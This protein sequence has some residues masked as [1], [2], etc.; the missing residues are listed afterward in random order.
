MAAFRCRNRNYFTR[1]LMPALPPT[2]LLL[3]LLLLLHHYAEI[4]VGVG[5]GTASGKMDSG[6]LVEMPLNE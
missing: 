2:P 1:Q 3:L 5:V 6:F 4:R